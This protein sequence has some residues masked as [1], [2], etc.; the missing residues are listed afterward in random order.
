MVL[1]DRFGSGVEQ[2]ELAHVQHLRIDVFQRKRC[3]EP[4]LHD[5]GAKVDVPGQANVF[6]TRRF[7]D[8]GELLG[9][10]CDFLFY[11]SFYRSELRFLLR[12]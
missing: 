6:G 12:C 5:E 8:F 1:Q 7:V 10:D 4:R 11:M 3:T 9:R 2:A